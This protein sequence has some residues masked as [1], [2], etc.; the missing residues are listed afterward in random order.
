VKN[1]PCCKISLHDDGVMQ[2]RFQGISMCWV[3]ILMARL[4]NE[5][6]APIATLGLVVFSSAARCAGHW[7]RFL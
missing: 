4:I 1:C 6:M 2:A 7:A 3:G 5:R